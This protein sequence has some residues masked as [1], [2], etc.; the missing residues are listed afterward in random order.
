MNVQQQ[1]SRAQQQQMQNPGNM[2]PGHP[3][4]QQAQSQMQAQMQ[5]QAAN[6]RNTMINS[7]ADNI[8]QVA[9]K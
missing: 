2:A 8:K 7:A 6:A 3:Q 4:Q 1:P 5:M 9:R